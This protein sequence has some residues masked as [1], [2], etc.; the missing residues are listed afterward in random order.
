M[1][2]EREGKGKGERGCEGEK[3]KP[4]KQRK[5]EMRGRVSEGGFGGNKNEEPSTYL[6]LDVKADG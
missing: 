5:M 3:R 6:E 1:E 4:R 2:W